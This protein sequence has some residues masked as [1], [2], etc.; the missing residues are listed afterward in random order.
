MV[1]DRPPGEGGDSARQATP[2]SAEIPVLGSLGA[3]CADVIRE[4]ALVVVDGAGI[5][6][7]W[8][9][10]AT[11]LFG[12]SPADAR[13]LSVD[14]VIVCKGLDPCLRSAIDGARAASRFE[15]GDR[16]FLGPDGEFHARLV[17]Y[18]AASAAGDERFCLLV[19]D[20]TERVEAERSL[21]R[22][23]VIQGAVSIVS[24]RIVA[25]SDLDAAINESLAEICAV[26]GAERA[27]LYVLQDGGALLD[28]TH[29]WL[30]G[31]A[32]SRV[33]MLQH[34]P[35]TLVPWWM[36][37]LEAGEVVLVSDT[38]AL[39][40]E[41]RAEREL[42]LERGVRSLVLL[43]FQVGERPTGLLL[44]ENLQTMEPWQQ[45]ELALLQVGAKII[46]NALAH[47]RAR[48]EREELEAQLRRSQRLEAIGRLAGGVAHEFNNALAV[49]LNYARFLA[50]AVPPDSALAKDIE[51]IRTA[52][53][54]ASDLTRHLLVFSRKDV[55]KP[56]PL[57]PNKVVERIDRLLRRTIGEHIDLRIDLGQP[58]A[59]VMA[60]PSQMDTLLFNLALNSREAMPGGGALKIETRVVAISEGVGR[61]AAIVPGHYVRLVVRDSGCGMTP[62]VAA[63]AFEPF[64]TTRERGKANGLGL[65]TVY[66][67]V[68]QAG[69]HVRLDS[70][71]GAG[72]TVTVLLPVTSQA[73]RKPA[74]A[75]VESAGEAPKGAGETILLVEDEL[76]VR[77]LIR[78]ML[79]RNGFKVVQAQHGGEVLRMLS[80]EDTPFDLLLTDI[81]TPH[82]S[83]IELAARLRTLRPNMR[84]LFMSGYTR[85]ALEELGMGVDAAEIVHKPFTE[86]NLLRQIRDA[87]HGKR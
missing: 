39:P 86:E 42:L 64:F 56:R 48:K 58:M 38:A 55:A 40:D 36:H 12:V 51:E 71:P 45:G 10:G 7:Y 73:G 24:S 27:Q 77:T 54:R 11:R 33:A 76:G 35:Q 4:H 60:D 37:K 53:E 61:A 15:V 59:H 52:G 70:T 74:T 19:E 23:L 65:S 78:R 26:V 41:A 85:E 28:C 29:E 2:A 17:V 46:G 83:G 44:L 14:E 79:T 87:I 68:S 5:V 84:V 16:R 43:P 66:G 62:D 22:Q 8:N 25:A 80:E 20:V 49:I 13:G 69:G 34:I 57:D 81:I 67:I 1:K 50:E 47:E 75:K 30:A 82:M 18:R 21:A 9:P 32:Q 3:G 63:R 31:D 6:Q 72:T